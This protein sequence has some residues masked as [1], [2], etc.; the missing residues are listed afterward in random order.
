MILCVVYGI[1]N[2]NKGAENE[3]EQINEEL[4]WEEEE[5]YIEDN[6]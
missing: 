3:D 4:I 5:H 2:W 6:L 1:I